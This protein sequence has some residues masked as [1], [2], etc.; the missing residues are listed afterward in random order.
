MAFIIEHKSTR[1]VYSHSL[2][3]NHIPRWATYSTLWS[4]SIL[5]SA[6]FPIKAKLINEENGNDATFPTIRFC[7]WVISIYKCNTGSLNAQGQ[8]Y[9]FQFRVGIM[10]VVTPSALFHHQW[11]MI[12]L[13]F[14][15][16]MSS[17]VIS[18]RDPQKATISCC[19]S[20]LPLIMAQSICALFKDAL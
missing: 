20:L 1:S 9:D 12:L 14:R 16:R 7:E 19:Y 10:R 6:M 4:T 8:K 5:S 3:L 17:W 2:P 13:L 18:W 15:I 11:I